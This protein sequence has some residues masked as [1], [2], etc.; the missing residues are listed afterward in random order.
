MEQTGLTQLVM[1]GG[2]SANK[3]LRAVL[4]EKLKAEV[5]YAPNH[6]CTDNGAMIAFAGHERL[7]NGQQEDLEIHVQPRWDMTTLPALKSVNKK[8]AKKQP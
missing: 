7:V 1:A 2:V 4:Q 8:P 3:K 5:F 6:L